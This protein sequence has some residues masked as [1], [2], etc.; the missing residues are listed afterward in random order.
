M[1]EP[2][3]IQDDLWSF[4]AP[5]LEAHG[6]RVAWLC[7]LLGGRRRRYPYRD[8]RDHALDLAHRLRASGIR[9][10][11]VV[12]I[13]CPNGPEWGVAALALWKL[14]AVVA[15]LHTGYSD[16]ELLAAV[17]ALRPKRV[18]T[19]GV[20]RRLEGGV[21]ILL[22]KD[23]AGIAAEARQTRPRQPDAEAVR[24]YTSGSSGT[25]KMVRLSH[26]N[27]IANVL[28]ATRCARIEGRDRFLSLLPL[29]HMMEITGGLVLPLHAGATIVLPR[30]LAAAEILDAMA[31]ERISVIIA[32]PR[33]YRNI[34]LGL[35]K[36]FRQAGPLLRGYLRLLRASPLWLRRRLNW[37]LRRRLGGRIQAWI[38]GGSRLD[39]S[40]ARYFRDLGLPLRQGYG[41]TETAPLIC[42]QEAF[43]PVLDSVGRPVAGVTVRIDRPGPDG[44]GE[45]LCRGPNVML[46]YV[47]KRQTRE[48]MRGGWFHTGDLAR[49]DDSGRVI[50]TGRSK[51]LIVTEAGKNVYPEE[52]ETLLERFPEVR[53]A[54]VIEVDMR[55]AAVLAVEGRPQ[56]ETARRV[57]RRF[58]ARVSGP[59]RINRFAL[60]DELP[61]TPVGKVAFNK[62]PEIFAEKEITG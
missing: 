49:V 53:E 30:V 15:P 27:I 29:S 13:L 14:G 40:I 37:P 54:G 62:L 2:T 61:R 47:D 28:A 41:L 46:G 16:A 58:N 12:A 10:G 48:V 42:L 20:D 5:S 45:L 52:L 50:L 11:D 23:P 1:V 19:H 26:R 4:L 7:R 33:L 35:E 51:R 38:S 44:S 25:P 8:I 18:L 6:R 31:A 22:E 9:S 17:A 24:I 3:P 60:V 57:L 34:M 21:P 56:V 32:V 55:P 36:R 43:D 39:P 59:N